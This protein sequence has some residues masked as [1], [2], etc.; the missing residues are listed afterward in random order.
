MRGDS[1][2]GGV[3]GGPWRTLEM[4]MM[5]KIMMMMMMRM[6]LTVMKMIWALSATPLELLQLD[7]EVASDERR[8]ST[9]RGGVAAKRCSLLHC[10]LE[11]LVATTTI[12]YQPVENSCHKCRPLSAAATPSTQGIFRKP[13]LRLSQILLNSYLFAAGFCFFFFLFLFFVVAA[14]PLLCIGSEINHWP[15]TTH[16]D[17]FRL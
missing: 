5:M 9:R 3:A 2:G 4:M 17:D 14:I 15:W 11:P 7:S 10:C 16:Q 6:E 13:N 12:H 1:G 8:A